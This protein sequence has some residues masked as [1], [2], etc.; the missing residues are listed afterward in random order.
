VGNSRFRHSWIPDYLLW[1]ER[2]AG[3]WRTNITPYRIRL[4]HGSPIAAP[5]AKRRGDSHFAE[6]HSND[7]FGIGRTAAATGSALKGVLVA[8]R[9]RSSESVTTSLTIHNTGS[10]MGFRRTIPKRTVD[11][12]D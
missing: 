10:S 2:V 9:I 1:K 5:G 7:P 12:R 4:K 8:A 3:S 11:A 6:R